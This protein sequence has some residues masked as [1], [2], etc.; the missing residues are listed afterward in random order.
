MRSPAA[1]GL[2]ALTPEKVPM[3]PAAAQAPELSPFETEMPLPPSTIGRTSRPEMTSGFK[4]ITWL[5]S[6]LRGGAP[7]RFRSRFRRASSASPQAG[8]DAIGTVGEERAHAP[9]QE[10]SRARRIVDRIDEQRVTRRAHCRDL[11]R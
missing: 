8:D 9:R 10:L 3:P 4:A 1:S 7:A 5:Y 11:C 6:S 2:S